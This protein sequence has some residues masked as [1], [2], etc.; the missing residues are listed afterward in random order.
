MMM[1]FSC[2]NPAKS[3]KKKNKKRRIQKTPVNRVF[4]TL[5]SNLI[6]W[7][8][9][10]DELTDRLL[11]EVLGCHNNLSDNPSLHSALFPC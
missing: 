11:T 8:L 6:F 7:N 2:E 9:R 5:R 3:V 10:I 4:Q 1:C